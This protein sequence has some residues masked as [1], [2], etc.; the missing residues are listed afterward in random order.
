MGVAVKRT[1]A[2]GQREVLFRANTPDYSIEDWVLNPDLTS[3]TEEDPFYW[4]IDTDDTIR[5]MTTE[6]K[7]TADLDRLELLKAA[8]ISQVSAVTQQCFMVG[9]ASFNSAEFSITP[10]AQ[11]N[12]MAMTIAAQF[13]MVSYPV[14]V[15]KQDGTPYHFHTKVEFLSFG[16]V[17]LGTVKYIV[18]IERTLIN[19]IQAATT[20][21]ALDAVVDPRI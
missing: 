4:F 16:Q 19:A 20:K 3:V 9:S 1:T 14:E 15:T 10:P 11:S 2:N 21:P 5:D 7:N 18:D 13:D 6:E 12:W 17:V 8:R